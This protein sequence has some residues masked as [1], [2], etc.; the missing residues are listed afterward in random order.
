MGRVLPKRPA[1]V[2]PLGTANRSQ[3]KLRVG[4][5]SGDLVGHPVGYFLESVLLQLDTARIELIA[6]TANPV[7]DTLTTR[8]KGHFIHWREIYTLNDQAVAQLIHSDGV[9]MLLDLSGHTAHNRLPVF[10]WKPAP[11]QVTWLG[12]FASTGLAE[13]D[14]LL[15]D[16]TGV[17]E[18]QR[19]H[20]SETI[21]Y[22]PDT[23]LCFTPPDTSLPVAPLPGL[24][25]G[26][27]TFGCY[28]N[29]S[30]LND[31][32]LATW[33][34]IFAALPQ[35]RLRLAA[36]QLG[37][38]AIAAQLQQ[39]LGKWGIGEARVSL[40]GMVPRQDYLASYAE[41]DMLLDTFPYPGGTTTCEALWMGVPTITL[42]GNTLL[43]RQGA[44][45]LT[46]AGLPDWI[47]QHEDDYVDKAVAFASD[48]PKLAALRANLREQVQ[49][50]PLFDA[51]RF[52]RHFE[53]ALWGM[54]QS[55]QERIKGGA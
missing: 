15:A 39:R 34:R 48:L 38:P 22:L 54:W 8:I 16:E 6:Y 25:N 36:P 49:S 19:S 1:H 51:P 7:V 5:V 55:K 52:A 12:Y 50:S 29:L 40:Y 11:V 41:A 24:G 18:S 21:W 45:L 27:I 14:Y 47:A 28:Q 13:M 17:P 30:K 46:A 42:A 26:Q 43:S 23:R 10:A 44:S 9:H 35:A 32:V 20:F 2:S 53:E 3:K 33:G 31:N 37:D 4:I